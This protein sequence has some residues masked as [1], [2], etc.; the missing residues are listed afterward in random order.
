MTKLY[1]KE[2]TTTTTYDGKALHEALEEAL[3]EA[4]AFIGL[5]MIFSGFL[6]I[7]AFNEGHPTIG[8]LAAIITLSS[9]IGVMSKSKLL[10]PKN[11]S[12][13]GRRQYVE[14]PRR[15]HGKK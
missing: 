11:P 6:A 5:V 9:L 12:K 8:V 3:E 1:V 13:L 7:W 10:A 15:T 4:L 2:E 14:L